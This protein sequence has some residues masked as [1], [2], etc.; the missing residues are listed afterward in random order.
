[1]SITDKEEQYEEEDREHQEEEHQ[2]LS[3]EVKK[4]GASKSP[5]TSFYDDH[6]F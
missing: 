3:M 2:N 1:M 5:S 4:K 6:L